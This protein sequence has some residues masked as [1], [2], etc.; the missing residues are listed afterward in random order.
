MRLDDHNRLENTQNTQHNQIR[1]KMLTNANIKPIH[2]N[3]F[4]L[5]M[6]EHKNI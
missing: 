3:I 6:L 4:C 1:A 5:K 2:A